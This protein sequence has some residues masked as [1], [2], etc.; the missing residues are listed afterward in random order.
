MRTPPPRSVVRVSPLLA[1]AFAFFV[2]AV[3]R[4]GES[5][6]MAA[7]FTWFGS[8]K[9]HDVRGLPFVHYMNGWS[10]THGEDELR[11]HWNY[12][13]LLSDTKDSFSILTFVLIRGN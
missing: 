7:D 4:A 9:F 11:L 13:W 6:D 12:G 5:S 10:T 1:F 8:L 2:C 3:T